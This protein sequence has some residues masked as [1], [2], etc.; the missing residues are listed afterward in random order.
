MRDDDGEE[1]GLPVD[2]GAR[3]R[4]AERALR[5]ARDM[6]ERALAAR[7]AVET[8]LRQLRARLTARNA[9]GDQ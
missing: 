1:I 4:A 5:E 7:L 2:N 9:A 3:A 6:A 8:E